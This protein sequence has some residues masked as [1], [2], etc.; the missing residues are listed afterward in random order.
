MIGSRK[1][2]AHGHVFYVRARRGNCCVILARVFSPFLE[3]PL[4][5]F[6]W[7]PPPLIRLPLSFPPSLPLLPSS[8]SSFLSC[9]LCSSFFR[10]S[11]PPFPMRLFSAPSRLLFLMARRFYTN[12]RQIDISAHD[13]LHSCIVHSLDF[14][15]PSSSSPPVSADASFRCHFVVQHLELGAVPDSSSLSEC[16]DDG[17]FVTTSLHLQWTSRSARKYSYKQENTLINICSDG[18]IGSCPDSKSTGPSCFAFVTFVA[19]NNTTTP[20]IVNLSAVLIFL[21]VMIS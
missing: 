19:T 18:T 16:I 20:D 7:L 8:C 4:F 1:L 13:K 5:F 14:V 21:A 2:N 15:P 17:T 11:L 9:L 6:C 12:L 10:P 3:F